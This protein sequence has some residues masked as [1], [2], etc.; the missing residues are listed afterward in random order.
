MQQTH[1][2]KPMNLVLAAVNLFHR[3]SNRKIK[4]KF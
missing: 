2:P 1:G 4:L 3:V